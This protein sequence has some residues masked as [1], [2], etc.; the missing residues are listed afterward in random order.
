[1]SVPQGSILGPLLFIVFR[2]GL[3]LHME[4][5]L[6]MYVDDSTLIADGKTREDLEVKIKPDLAKVNKWCNKMVI[7]CYNH[8]VVNYN[9]TKRSQARHYTSKCNM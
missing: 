2:N 5:S 6:D 3:P 7:K 9:M 8:A 4:S 1:M